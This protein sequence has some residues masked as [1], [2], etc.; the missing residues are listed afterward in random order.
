MWIALIIPQ[1]VTKGGELRSKCRDNESS[2][3]V[4][5]A[6]GMEYYS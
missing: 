6:V 3:A 5:K 4:D 2:E 1:A